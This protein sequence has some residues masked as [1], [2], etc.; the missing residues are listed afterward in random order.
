LERGRR[1]G[2]DNRDPNMVEEKEEESSLSSTSN[3]FM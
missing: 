3:D 1:A 2:F